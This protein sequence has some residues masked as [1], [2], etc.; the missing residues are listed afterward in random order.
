MRKFLSLSVTL[1]M[2]F[3]L[4]GCKGSIFGYECYTAAEEYEKIFEL[5]EL[6]YAESAFELFPK[7]ISDITVE[8][9]YCEWELGIVG[10]AVAEICL[11]ASYTKEE[12]DEEILRLKLLANGN[13]VYNDET[14][15]YPAYVL[16]LGYYN[17]SWYAL[18]DEENLRVNYV[19]LQL[20]T[21]SEIDIDNSLVPKGYSEHGDVEGFE[22]NSYNIEA[23]E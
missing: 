2:L 20:V 15:A 19:L 18:V 14:F 12:F 23:V 13:I 8:N 1:V 17:T 16:V 5:T 10:S 6:R 4:I 21:E 7:D 11:S 22:F 9:F 3:S